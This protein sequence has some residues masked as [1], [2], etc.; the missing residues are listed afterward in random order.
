MLA[1]FQQTFIKD[2]CMPGTELWINRLTIID[3]VPTLMELLARI[4]NNYT[5]V[6]KAGK[7]MCSAVKKMCSI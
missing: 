6:T 4:I 5:T 7:K 2:Y 1:F 3:T